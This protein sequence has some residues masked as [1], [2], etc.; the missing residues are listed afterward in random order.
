MVSVSSSVE[1]RY[2]E[3]EPIPCLLRCDIHLWMRG[4]VLLRNNPYMA[5]SDA[6][7]RFSIRHLPAGE[8]TFRLWHER[9]GYLRDVRFGAQRTDSKGRLTLKIGEGANELVEVRLNPVMFEDDQ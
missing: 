1:L 9:V 3:Q 8:R 7:G 4:Y 6:H 2:T 5:V